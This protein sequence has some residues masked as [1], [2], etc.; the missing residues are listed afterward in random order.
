M[1]QSIH[2]NFFGIPFET[3]F[4]LPGIYINTSRSCRTAISENRLAVRRAPT[5]LRPSYLRTNSQGYREQNYTL[6]NKSVLCT[7]YLS[8]HTR[9]SILGKSRRPCQSHEGVNRSFI[10][11]ATDSKLDL[12]TQTGS[13]LASCPFPANRGAPIDRQ[14]RQRELPILRW[15]LGEIR[16]LR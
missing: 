6:R 1:W 9:R 15:S 11:C 13:P 10:P 8:L 16:R 7:P 3:P 4:H 5:S 14:R 2:S 12:F